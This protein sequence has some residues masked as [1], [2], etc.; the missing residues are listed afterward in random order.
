[1]RHSPF[2]PDNLRAVAATGKKKEENGGNQHF[3]HWYADYGVF[4]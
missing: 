3:P 4:H 1:M 2:V